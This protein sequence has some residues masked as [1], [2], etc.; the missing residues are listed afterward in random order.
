MPPHRSA[1]HYGLKVNWNDRL[2]VSKTFGG[3]GN[4]A[5]VRRLSTKAERGCLVRSTER[6]EKPVAEQGFL[7]KRGV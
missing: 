5:A 7:A 4:L 1:R 6:S 2:M 3:M